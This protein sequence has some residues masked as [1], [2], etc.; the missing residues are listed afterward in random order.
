MKPT[1]FSRG[2]YR[3]YEAYTIETFC[4]VFGGEN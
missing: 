3:L 4:H 2:M 1:Q